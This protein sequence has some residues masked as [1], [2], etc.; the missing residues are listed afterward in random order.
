[1]NDPARG[2]TRAFLQELGNGRLRR[3]EALL[4]EH[5]QSLG[6]PCAPYTLKRIQRRQLPLSRDTLV[7]GD[8]DAMH[9]AMQQLKID[10]PKPNDYPASLAPT[11][12]VASGSPPWAKCAG[13]SMK[14][15][16]Q[17]CSP[18]L[19]TVENASRA[20]SSTHRMTSTP[21]A[22]RACGKQCGAPTWWSGCLNIACM[23]EAKK[24]SKS[25]TTPGIQ[26]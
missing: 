18:N 22:L 9:G 15:T 16:A 6:I 4:Q 19:R 12:G 23:P 2:F 26:A 7:V 3:E 1:M 21:L 24:S 20:G 8:M 5:L 17:G 13:M 11:S 25:T 10:I 14:A